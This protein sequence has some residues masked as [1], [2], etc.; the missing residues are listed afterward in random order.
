MKAFRFL[1]PLL[2]LASSF[3]HPGLLVTESDLTRLQGKLSTQLE[4]CDC[5]RSLHP[6]AVSAV[7]RDN[8]ANADLLWQD[9]AAPFALALRWKVESNTSYAGAATDTLNSWGEKLTSIG[10]SDDQYSAK[11]TGW[12]LSKEATLYLSFTWAS[13]TCLFMLF[14]VYSR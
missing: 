11:R 5:Q 13:E 2:P 6:Q 9:A 7:D 4:P 8:E 1:L 10:T 3:S 12:R 14:W